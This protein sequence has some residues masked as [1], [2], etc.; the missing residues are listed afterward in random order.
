[1]LATQTLDLEPEGM[2]P[3]F[4]SELERQLANPEE[5]RLDIWDVEAVI[6]PGTKCNRCWR[7]THDTSN[8]GIWKDVCARCQSALREMGIDPPQASG[9]PP[10]EAQPAEGAQ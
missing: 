9:A 4:A 1:L 2:Q 10:A 7:Y 3:H 5:A 6:A 8:Y